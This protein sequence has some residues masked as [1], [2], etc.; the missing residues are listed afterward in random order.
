DRFS[1]STVISSCDGVWSLATSLLHV[2][3]PHLRNE[4]GYGAAIS[5][6]EKG[7]EWNWALELV[8]CMA[9][10]ALVPNTTCCNS[11]ISACEKKGFSWLQAL[12]VFE[13]MASLRIKRASA[14]HYSLAVAATQKIYIK[15][16][17]F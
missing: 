5:A 13:A 2:H 10:A 6:C 14:R 16:D 9:V 3:S 15:E 17:L 8:C 12:K 11:A 1:L 7:S 4:V